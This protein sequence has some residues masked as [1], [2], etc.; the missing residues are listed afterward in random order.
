MEDALELEE[1]HKYLTK[2]GIKTYFPKFISTCRRWKGLG[3][4]DTDD[5][6]DR[7]VEPTMHGISWIPISSIERH[8]AGS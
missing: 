7:H 2:F 6:I 8:L 1:R 3:I 5:S 4:F